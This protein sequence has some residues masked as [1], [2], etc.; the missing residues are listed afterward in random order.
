[1]STIIIYTTFIISPYNTEF[2]F[3]CFPT[4]DSVGDCVSSSACDWSTGGEICSKRT[5]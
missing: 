5:K 3:C 2:L 1:M 4:A